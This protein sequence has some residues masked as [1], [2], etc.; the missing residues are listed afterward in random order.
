MSAFFGY[1]TNITYYLLFA[2]V[3]NL[4]APSGKYKKF[5]TL[6][7]GFVLVVIVIAPLRNF[8]RDFNAADFF[9][10]IP[11]VQ[12]DLGDLSFY[13]DE[14]LSAAFEE[15]LFIQLEAMLSRYRFHLRD[16][17]FLY[18]DD[19]SRIT[20]VQVTVS[21]EEETRR[22][23]FIRIEPVQ[24]NRNQPETDPAIDEIKNLIADFYNIPHGHIH[25]MIQMS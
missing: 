8:G 13:H 14:Q 9:T 18:T 12:G 25:V 3:V 20:S 5:V 17:A 2:A 11:L 6:V 7:T 1:I 21:R 24:I 4:L 15:Q 16:A 10:G 23:P 22:V 19:F